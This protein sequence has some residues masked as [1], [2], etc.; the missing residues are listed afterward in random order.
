MAKTIMWRIVKAGANESGYNLKNISGNGG[1]AKA[2]AAAK[3]I[4]R[5]RK[6][7]QWRAA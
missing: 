4:M 2:S 5:Q 1:M 6:R 7:R 3:V